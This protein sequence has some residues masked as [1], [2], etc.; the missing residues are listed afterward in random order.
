MESLD[1]SQAISSIGSTVGIPACI[2]VAWLYMKVKE[3]ERRLNEGSNRFDK[4]D[5]EL[6]KINKSLFTLIGK[7]NMMLRNS[8][9]TPEE[10]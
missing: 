8:G 4:L 6:S 10:E 9:H 2:L 3:L 5:T 7:V 1:I